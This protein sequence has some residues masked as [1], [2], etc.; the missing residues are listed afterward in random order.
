VLAAW[1]ELVGVMGSCCFFGDFALGLSLFEPDAH[2]A[3]VK[4]LIAT[5]KRG[6]QRTRR[7]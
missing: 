7:R 5:V 1:V 6:K 2:S 4:G 3:P